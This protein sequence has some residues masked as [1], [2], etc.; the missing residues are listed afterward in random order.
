MAPL[1]GVTPV[2]GPLACVTPLGG[3][4]ASVTPVGGPPGEC[5]ALGWPPK[6][7]SILLLLFSILFLFFT[8]FYYLCVFL[9]ATA[10]AAAFVTC[11]CPAGSTVTG[12]DL[13]RQPRQQ[14]WW[15]PTRRVLHEL[16]APAAGL[17]APLGGCLTN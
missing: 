3:P 4:V 10:A 8:L 14:R 5:D 7:V 11:V 9:Q 17:V 1:A 12:A 15:H 16:V 2:G 13:R 6:H